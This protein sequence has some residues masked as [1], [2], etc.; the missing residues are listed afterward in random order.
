M[1][2]ELPENSLITADAGFVGYDFW[3]SILEAGP[4]F[5]IRVGANVKLLGETGL[6]PRVGSHRLPVARSGG[7]EKKAAVGAAA[8]GDPRL[9]QPVYLVTS[10]LSQ[11]HLSDQQAI[12]IYRHRW[13]IEEAFQHL[14]GDLRCEI[15]TLAYPTRRP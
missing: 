12:E 10:V 1:L 5:V 3:T 7:Q 4:Q 14:Q 6:R 11:P 15:D 9:I 8:D 13:G 2:G